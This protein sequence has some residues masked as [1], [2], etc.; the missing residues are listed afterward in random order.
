MPRRS[1]ARRSGL[2]SG[3][4]ARSWIQTPAVPRKRVDD[5][6]EPRSSAASRAT[7]GAARRSCGPERGLE[8][9][10]WRGHDARRRGCAAAVTRGTGTVPVRTG[11]SYA[12]AFNT[13]ALPTASSCERRRAQ[14]TL[15]RPAGANRLE[16]DPG[17][18]R[19][20]PGAV[21]RSTD[22]PP[23]RGRDSAPS[24]GEQLAVA[25]ERG[26]RGGAAPASSADRESLAGRTCLAR[27]ARGERRADALEH[28]GRLPQVLLAELRAERVG[29]HLLRTPGSCRSTAIRRA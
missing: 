5:G 3:R 4:V 15:C 7:G 20:G 14:P 25:G 29:P 12:S 21:R 23:A 13:C 18:R 24:R 6:G 16:R 11:R 10:L 17:P 1:G 2:R 19:S 22:R 9:R 28:L 26:V 8:R 27:R